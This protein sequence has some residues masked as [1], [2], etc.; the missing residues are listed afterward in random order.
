[1]WLNIWLI[2]LLMVNSDNLLSLRAVKV[3]IRGAGSSVKLSPFFEE[4]ESKND[5]KLPSS[6]YWLKKVF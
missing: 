3:S 1:M 4:A 6:C 2:T 5:F